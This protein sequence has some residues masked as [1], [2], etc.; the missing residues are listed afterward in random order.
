MVVESRRLLVLGCF[1][2]WS[3]ADQEVQHFLIKYNFIKGKHRSPI[4]Y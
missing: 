4:Y 2:V 1:T 3:I